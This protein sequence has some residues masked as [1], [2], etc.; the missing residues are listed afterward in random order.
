MAKILEAEAR[1]EATIKVAEGDAMAIKMI[2]EADP[3]QA[4]LTLK[5]YEAFMK[6][7]DGQS[8][9]II[10]PSEIQSLAGM[11]TSIKELTKDEE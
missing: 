7:A 10:I 2:K 4:I 3:D 5:G 1:K 6:A 9:K 8:T 11:V